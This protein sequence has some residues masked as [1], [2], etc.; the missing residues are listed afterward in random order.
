[1]NREQLHSED[2]NRLADAIRLRVYIPHN[3]I[4][5]HVPLLFINCQSW[6][7]PSVV[8]VA[9]KA[10]PPHSYEVEKSGRSSSGKVPSPSCEHAGSLIYS[11]QAPITRCL[12][13]EGTQ[14]TSREL[15]HVKAAHTV[16]S[17]IRMTINDHL[18]GTCWAPV[19]ITLW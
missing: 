4:F 3:D 6:E 7:N 5:L 13:R 14:R 10:L 18:L 12:E 1:M 15:G 17:R 9:T 11:S 8:Q 16:R 19:T 2:K